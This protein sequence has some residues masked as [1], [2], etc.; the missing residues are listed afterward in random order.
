MDIFRIL[1]ENIDCG[2]TLDLSPEVKSVNDLMK[3][4]T[5]CMQNSLT[6]FVVWSKKLQ[7][8]KGQ[9]NAQSE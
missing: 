8:G 3:I 5:L 9:E 4:N 7:E 6:S 2:Y 1:P